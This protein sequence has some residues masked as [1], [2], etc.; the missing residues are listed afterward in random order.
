MFTFLK[1]LFKPEPPLVI[2][3]AMSRVDR[4]IG[5][6]NDLLWHIPDDLKRFK[7]LTRG[8]PVIMGRKTFESIIKILGKPLPGRTNIVVTRDVNYKPKGTVTA[9]NLEEAVEIAKSENP[10]EIHIGGGAELY[11]QYLP[12]V[13][14]LHVTWVDDKRIADTFFPP[15]E[16]AFTVTETH[17]PREHGHLRYQWIDY[18]RK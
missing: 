7:R 18:K 5:K 2:V 12:R 16:E 15:F 6:N 14:K 11:R 8:H 3:T 10:A 9:N 17:E 1:K 4:A 13:S